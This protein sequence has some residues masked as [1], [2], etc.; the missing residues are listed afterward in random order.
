MGCQ[1]EAIGSKLFIQPE[2]I[3]FIKLY[4]G[5]KYELIMRTFC[6]VREKWFQSSKSSCFIL[7]FG[8]ITTNK[9]T[10]ID[11]QINKITTSNVFLHSRRIYLL[12]DL[13]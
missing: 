11:K 8:K 2:I 12:T 1:G 9:Q 10:Q 13:L 6:H 3:Q 4:F 7:S 5:S